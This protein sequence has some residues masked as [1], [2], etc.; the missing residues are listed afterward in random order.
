[1][2]FRSIVAL[3][4]LAG[5]PALAFFSG[6]TFNS[7]AR[8]TRSEIPLSARSIAVALLNELEARFE[9]MSNSLSPR[10]TEEE[11][12]WMKE[13]ERRHKKQQEEAWMREQQKLHAQQQQ[14]PAHGAPRQQLPPPPHQQHLPQYQFPAHQQPPP[15]QQ[16]QT[17]GQQ[18]RLMQEEQE[19]ARLR[20]NIWKE[21]EKFVQEAQLGTGH[22]PTTGSNR[23]VMDADARKAVVMRSLQNLSIAQLHERWA[24]VHSGQHGTMRRRTGRQGQL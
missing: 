4:A 19:K 17:Q 3:S 9:P 11:E 8:T 6:Q 18:Q 14:R 5:A 12:R 10:I 16:Q 2:Y 24:K 23:Q 22:V 13:Q 15:Q 1:M 21:Q 7:R 20:E